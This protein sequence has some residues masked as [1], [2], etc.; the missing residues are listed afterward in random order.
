ML[1][2][3]SHKG[4]WEI[5]CDMSLALSLFP[6]STSLSIHF[7]SKVF[8]GMGNIPYVY[9]AKTNGK[10]NKQKGNKQ[11]TVNITHTKVVK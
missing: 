9:I 6:L 10:D 1:R 2:A 7:N 3:H 11:E 4:L 5:G 8:I